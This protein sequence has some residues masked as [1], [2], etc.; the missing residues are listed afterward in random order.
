MDVSC[1]NCGAHYELDTSRF[2]GSSLRVQCSSCG[3]V[4]RV[5]KNLSEIS[6]PALPT[7]PD[8]S[9][10]WVIRYKDGALSIVPDKATLQRWIVERRVSPDDHVSQDEIHWRTFAEI[11]EFQ[12]FFLVVA[13]STASHLGVHQTGVFAAP[14][15]TPGPLALTPSGSIQNFATLGLTPA[16]PSPTQTTA[17][18]PSHFAPSPILSAPT[19]TTSPSAVISAPTQTTAPSSPL[20]LGP[21]GSFDS[22]PKATLE[23][24]LA[25]A[26]QGL[27]S[28]NP[29]LLAAAE[30]ALASSESTIASTEAVSDSDIDKTSHTQ[31]RTEISLE[32]ATETHTDLSND[33][34]SVSLRTAHLDD[35]D[36]HLAPPQDF[37]LAPLPNNSASSKHLDTSTAS[38]SSKHLDTSTTSAS[39]KHL[40]TSTASASSKHLDTSTTSASSKHLDTSTASAS[41]AKSTSSTTPLASASSAKS[42]TSKPPTGEWFMGS[43]DAL[44]LAAEPAF[45]DGSPLTRDPDAPSRDFSVDE[46]HTV[47]EEDLAFQPKKLGWFGRFAIFLLLLSSLGAGLYLLQPPWSEPLWIRL[48]LLEARAAS[49]NLLQEVHIQQYALHEAAWQRATEQLKQIETIE[50]DRSFL[51]L[52]LARAQQQLTR[53]EALHL[54]L[55]LNQQQQERTRQQIKTVRQTL[56]TL[57]P[58]TPQ[59]AA[60]EQKLQNFQNSASQDLDR[61]QQQEKLLQ[62]QMSPLVQAAQQQLLLAESTDRFDIRTLLTK[63]HFSA[64]SPNSGPTTRK[65]LEQLEKR[66]LSPELQSSLLLIRGALS[67]RENQTEQASEDLDPVCQKHPNWVWPILARA[68]VWA[69]QRKTSQSIQEFK[70]AIDLAKQQPLAQQWLAFL[71][72]PQPDLTPPKAPPSKTSSPPS[73]FNPPSNT[74]NDDL[75]NRPLPALI[76]EAERLRQREKCNAALRFYYAALKKKRTGTIF[77][78]LGWC[79]LE[80]NRLPKAQSYFQTALKLDANNSLALFGLGLTFRRRG[81]KALAKQTFETYLQRFPDSTDAREVKLILQGL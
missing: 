81:K 27:K 68:A 35:H 6:S 48:R 22:S 41:P 79:T 13:Q 18:S 29:A 71:Q 75:D 24:G 56:A 49:K 37:Y 2:K 33:L 46:D 61:L 4:F 21:A 60:F 47:G 14:I 72:S 34:D 67:L 12:P 51:G 25:Q 15:L 10:K 42:A 32:A 74:A 20:S 43:S 30:A 80:A 8:P 58:Q 26:L 17:P 45:Q 55:L 59:R 62:Q 40:D 69:I 3:H 28:S 76:R 52:A 7:L 31:E 64:I 1:E 53:I 78:G 38:A 23:F 19:Q 9:K 57:P 50:G 66:S 77:A 63:A 5:Q 65:A 54:S 44:D 70:R 36:D 16:I 11:E 73:S 39:S